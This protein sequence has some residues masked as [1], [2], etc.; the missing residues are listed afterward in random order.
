[1]NNG[2]I[3]LDTQQNVGSPIVVRDEHWPLLGRLH[4]LADVLIELSLS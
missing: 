4:G 2:L 3:I 1:M